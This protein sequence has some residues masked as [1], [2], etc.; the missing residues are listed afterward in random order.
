[1]AKQTILRE[2]PNKFFARATPFFTETEKGEAKR[3]L[4]AISN[5]LIQKIRGDSASVFTNALEAIKQAQQIIDGG[6]VAN[7]VRGND[8]E[9]LA[10]SVS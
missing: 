3:R 8:F 6:D 1:V 2:L 5:S 9:F 10:D 7:P 4:T